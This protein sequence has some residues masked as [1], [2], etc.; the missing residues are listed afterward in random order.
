MY[1]L[2][3][4]PKASCGRLSPKMKLV[5][6]ITLSLLIDPCGGAAQAPS[7]PNEGNIET[8]IQE[9][10]MQISSIDRLLSTFQEQLRAVYDACPS[11]RH[12]DSQT[13]MDA[14]LD[15]AKQLGSK[16][17]AIKE[18]VQEKTD[19]LERMTRENAPAHQESA[20]VLEQ[21]IQELRRIGSDKQL[22]RVA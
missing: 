16:V 21:R 12:I 5:W 10:E 20:E 18:D 15:E 9:L 13:D 22:P 7:E 11:I 8:Q 1:A 6:I 14:L 19:L 17:N 2:Q 4:T 3:V